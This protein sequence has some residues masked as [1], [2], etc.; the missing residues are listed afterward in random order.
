[1]SEYRIGSRYAKSLFHEAAEKNV[2]D[3]IAADMENVSQAVASSRELLSL[4]RSPVVNSAAKLAA[5]KK[6]FS[7]SHGISQQFFE[8]M[9]SKK[10]EEYLPATARVFL[11]L[12]RESKGIASASVTSAVELD[13]KTTESIREFLKGKTGSSEV[14][15]TTQVDP[16]IIGGLV[17]RFG[18]KLYDTSIST[19]IN[20]L[21]QELNIV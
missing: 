19:Q 14:E 13:K 1:M 15:L 16:S 12:Y 6:I 2:L 18:D 9:I 11:D 3:K 10:R 4:L 5:L 21:K 20:K 8:L 7:H 17:I